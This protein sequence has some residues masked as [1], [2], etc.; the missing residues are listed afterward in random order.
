MLRVIKINKR[1]TRQGGFTLVEILVVL[2]VLA[3][4]AAAA[5]PLITQQTQQGYRKEA[6]DHLA[7][8]RDAMS[9]YCQTGGEP[10]ATCYNGVA[11]WTD[12]S[13]NPNATVT[14][15]TSNFTYALPAITGLGTGFDC[16][17]T[18]VGSA[19][20]LNVNIDEAGVITYP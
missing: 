10:A 20:G 12:I 8:V 4:I 5:L 9:V 7:A 13:F 15:Q 2:V 11:A 1:V 17:A 3:I 18:G 6:I 19:L 14:G 16:L